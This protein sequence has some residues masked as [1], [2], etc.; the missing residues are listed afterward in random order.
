MKSTQYFTLTFGVIYLVLGILGLIPN[1][2]ETIDSANLT[3]DPDLNATFSYLLGILPVNNLSSG[4]N[5]LLGLTGIAT[6]IALDSA[7]AFSGLLGIIMTAGAVLGLIPYADT[8]FGLTPLFGTN[9][10]LHAITAV[11]AIYFG[12]I[13]TPDLLEISGGKA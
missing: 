11:F 1:A 5:L 10:I 8:L 4:I 12:F 6:A 7:R 2:I 13:K 3:V 9:V